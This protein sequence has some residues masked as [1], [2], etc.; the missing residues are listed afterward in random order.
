MPSTV[1]RPIRI[2]CLRGCRTNTKI[3]RLQLH[4]LQDAMGRSTLFRMVNA[5]YYT[6]AHD[7]LQ[8]RQH[9]GPFYQ[10]YDYCGDKE[11]SRS[12]AGQQRYIAY[13]VRQVDELGPFDAVLGFSQG[14]AKTTMLTAYYVAKKQ[15]VPFKAIALFCGYV[16]QDGM[17]EALRVEPHK[18]QF[19]FHGPSIH[20]LGKQ[21]HFCQYGRMLVEWFKTPQVFEHAR[22]HEFPPAATHKTYYRGTAATL[23]HMCGKNN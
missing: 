21:D 3:L 16:P 7:S 5:P 20:V 17:P 2:L 4:G 12:Y 11:A 10:W 9:E 13:L 22:G 23:R 14:A 19:H 18:Q 15:A 1:P 8:G 6:T